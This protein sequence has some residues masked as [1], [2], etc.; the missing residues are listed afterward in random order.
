MHHPSAF[1]LW[2]A[3]VLTP[4]AQARET[5]VPQAAVQQAVQLRERAMTD[6]TG[7]RI[8]E[9]LTTEVRHRMPGTE[10]DARGVA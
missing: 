1:M 7:W 5:R 8:V 6:D 2:L 4:I 10:H 9:S 3:L